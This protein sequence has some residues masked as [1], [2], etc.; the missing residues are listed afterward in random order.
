M[1]APLLRGRFRRESFYDDSED[2]EWLLSQP[3]SRRSIVAA[4]LPVAL[5]GICAQLL[6]ALPLHLAAYAEAE[7]EAA[8]LLLANEGERASSGS[9]SGYYYAQSQQQKQPLLSVFAH[10]GA[11]ATPSPLL[12]LI[13]YNTVGLSFSPPPSLLRVLAISAAATYAV[14]MAMA[15]GAFTVLW[16]RLLDSIL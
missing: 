12:H 9:G 2:E 1:A 3:A 6:I 11:V 10:A 13:L 15:T 5:L 16:V 8:S 7:A 14:G 4:R